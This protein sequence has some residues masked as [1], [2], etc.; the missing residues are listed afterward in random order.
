MRLYVLLVVLLLGAFV[1]VAP[2]MAATPASTSI[3]FGTVENQ[4]TDMWYE[5]SAAI[6]GLCLVFSIILLVQGKGRTNR[7]RVAAR[8]KAIRASAASTGKAAKSVRSDIGSSARAIRSSGHAA[9]L[10]FKYR[11]SGRRRL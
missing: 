6:V 7:R 3:D 2:A 9:R 10:D 11:G 1:V 5:G 4:I 8:S